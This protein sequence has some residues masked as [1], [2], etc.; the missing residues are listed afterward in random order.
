M[1]SLLGIVHSTYI[2]VTNCYV[3]PLEK[4]DKGDDVNISFSKNANK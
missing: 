2:E 4:N 1:G 3:V